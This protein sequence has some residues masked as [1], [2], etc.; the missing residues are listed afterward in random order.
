MLHLDQP[1]ILLL[2]IAALGMAAQVIASWLR[3]PSI[4]PLLLNVMTQDLSVPEKD[5]TLISL[6]PTVEAQ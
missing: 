5:I 2:L 1:V 6:A 3:V 4:L